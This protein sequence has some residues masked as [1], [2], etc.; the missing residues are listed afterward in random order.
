MPIEKQLTWSLTYLKQ[1]WL[2]LINC[3]PHLLVVG[4]GARSYTHS[5]TGSQKAFFFKSRL[6]ILTLST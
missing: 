1:L 3:F 5:T 6:F 4:R 2:A